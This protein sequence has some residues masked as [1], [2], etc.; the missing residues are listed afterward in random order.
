MHEE[1]GRHGGG[2]GGAS[3]NCR[4]GSAAF[5]GS[6]MQGEAPGLLPR[7][8]CGSAGVRWEN[9]DGMQPMNPWTQCS[10]L[11]GAAPAQG[12]LC[13]HRQLGYSHGAGAAWEQRPEQESLLGFGHLKAGGDGGRGREMGRRAAEAADG[14]PRDTSA[15]AWCSPAS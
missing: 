13:P 3:I 1:E 2:Q 9:K 11:L 4:G 7:G 15:G 10:C 8:L 12:G 5:P 14:C 6:R